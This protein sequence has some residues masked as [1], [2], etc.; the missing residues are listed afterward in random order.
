MIVYLKMKRQPPNLGERFG[1]V[2]LGEGRKECIKD[3]ILVYRVTT[4]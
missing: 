1:G 3:L 2:A 4:V